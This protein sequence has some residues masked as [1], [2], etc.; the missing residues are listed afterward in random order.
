M[1]RTLNVEF[2]TVI[3]DEAA[4]CV[5]LSALIPLKYGCAKCIVVGDPQQLPPTVFSRD[6]ARFKYEQSLFVRMQTNH[7][8]DVHLLDTQYRMHPEI[9][10]F[11]SR[12]FYDSRL[13]DGA[14]LAA[15]RTRPWHG[16]ALLSPYRFFDV[17]GQHSAMG[18]SLVNH[19]EVRAALQL[20]H[21]LTTDFGGRYD[22]NGKIGIITPY[23]SQLKELKMQFER[24]LGEDVASSIEFN[25]TDAF[26][27]REAEI[28]IFSCVRA[29]PG[30]GIGFLNDIRRMNVG[31]TRAKCSLWVLGNSTSLMKGEFWAKLVTE[32]KTR[33]RYTTGDLEG[34][35]KRPSQIVRTVED[36]SVKDLTSKKKVDEPASVDVK[37]GGTSDSED[38][39]IV[40]SKPVVK[41]AVKSE[42]HVIKSER[43]DLKQEKPGIKPTQQ[44]KSAHP[45]KHGTL[46]NPIK[47]ESRKP[48]A[49]I[50]KATSSDRS[51]PM[52]PTTAAPTTLK[53]K[54]SATDDTEMQDYTS[55]DSSARPS[56]RN[57]DASSAA[58]RA[59]QSGTGTGSGAGASGGGSANASGG[60]RSVAP[61]ARPPQGLVRK[62]ADPFI[63]KK[64]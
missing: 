25:T 40:E 14:G 16:T 3:I 37:M 8:K 23:K 36:G 64:R 53:R 51:S 29:S 9:S 33:D 35:L 59:P 34:L 60:A 48:S 63:R 24:Q 50:P 55:R 5:E 31:L 6:A 61:K 19:A 38:G 56:S 43:Q 28:I 4:Q 26:Q 46:H 42:Q 30:T 62:K 52:E 27:G 44:V 22:F 12:M 11:P 57:S 45:I 20:Y 21:R 18:H 1:F 39:E 47:A 54:H 15:L 32:S 2:E 17:Q 49:L 10:G 58:G 7:S 13:L 41:P